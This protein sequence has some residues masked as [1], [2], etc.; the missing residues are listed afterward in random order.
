[1]TARVKRWVL[2]HSLLASLLLPLRGVLSFALTIAFTSSVWVLVTQLDA[3]DT[4]LLS[5][6]LAMLARDRVRLEKLAAEGEI[7]WG[8]MH[9]WKEMVRLLELVD[10]P[11]TVGFQ[12]D[13]AHTLLY[14][15][16][17]NAEPEDRLVPENFD[18]EPDR[19]DAAR[20]GVRSPAT[21]HYRVD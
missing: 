16:G 14:T 19:L 7:C 15:L 10:R 9:S 5:V 8:G 21:G 11:Q 20:L 6:V 3:Q 12:A 4:R 1:M 13:M 18:W 17:Y 2:A